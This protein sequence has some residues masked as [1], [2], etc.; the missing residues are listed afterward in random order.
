[1]AENGDIRRMRSNWL[2]TAN[3]TVTLT[4]LIPLDN[5]T[6]GLC[7]VPRRTQSFRGA[8]L[9]ISASED[10]SKTRVWR[11]HAC[12]ILVVQNSGAELV[13]NSCMFGAGLA[14]LGV[15]KYQYTSLEFTERVPKTTPAS[16]DTHT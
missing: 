12:L 16:W 6:G 4:Q 7:A 5:R 14:L 8:T 1:M 2:Y 10:N 15:F 13:Q 9:G 3:P 11:S